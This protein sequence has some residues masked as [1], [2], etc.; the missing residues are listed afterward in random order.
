MQCAESLEGS[1]R[2]VVGVVP[3]LKLVVDFVFVDLGEKP[4]GRWSSPTPAPM[5]RVRHSMPVSQTV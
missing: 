2:D 5:Y 1:D 3:Q 4:E